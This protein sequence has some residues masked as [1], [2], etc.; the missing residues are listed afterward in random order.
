MYASPWLRLA[1]VWTLWLAPLHWCGLTA[2]DGWS[3]STTA[4]W[5][6]G[7]STFNGSSYSLPLPNQVGASGDSQMVF[8]DPAP[9]TVPVDPNLY[10]QPLATVPYQLNPPASETAMPRVAEAVDLPDLNPPASVSTD[11]PAADSGSASWAELTRQEAAATNSLATE[12][13][14]TEIPLSDVSTAATTPTMGQRIDSG[15]AIDEPPLAQETVR[16]YRYPWRWMTRGWKN[17]AEFGVDGSAGNAETLAFQT[18]AELKR[19]TDLYT[20]AVDIDYRFA[21][22]GDVTT[23]N[24]GR[25]NVDYDRLVNN[26][27]WSLFGK[28]GLEWDKFKAFDLR[29]NLNGGIGYHWIRNDRTTFVTRFGAGAMRKIGAPIDPWIAEAVFGLDGEHQLNK[30]NKLKG[31]VDYFPAWEDFNTYRIVTDLGWEILLDEAENLSVKFGVSDRYDNNPQGARPNDF[32]YSA[33]LLVK[34]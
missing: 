5:K 7:I 28:Y 23:E 25:W 6:Q 3:T 27:P 20:L 15:V 33:L 21:N 30:R 16:W 10:T 8:D 11:Q 34:F 19:K 17:H 26:S 1:L 22:A 14:A 31:K 18:G 9:Y 12:I 32:Y 24:N 13:P 4:P 2:A 29:V